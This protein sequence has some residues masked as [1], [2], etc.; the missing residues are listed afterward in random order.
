LRTALVFVGAPKA[1]LRTKTGER[2]NYPIDYR[3]RDFLLKQI[4]NTLAFYDP[5]VVDPAGGFYHCY[6]NNGALFNP[7]LKTLVAS[8]RFVFNYAKAY[9][10]FGKAEYKAHVVHGLRY[11][12]DVHRNLQTGGYAWRIQDG[13]VVD[14]TNHCYGLAFVLLA[15]ACAT[16][17][18]IAEARQWIAETYDLMENRFWLEDYGLY[19]CEADADWTLRAYRGQND[20]MHA[21]EALIAAY[22]STGESRYLERACLLAENI[23]QRQTRETQGH[24]LEHYKADWT[25][26]RDYSRDDKSNAMR[27]WGVQTGH[28]TEWAKLLIILDR[29]QPEEWRLARARELFDR[30]M[31]YGWDKERGGLIHNYDLAGK[32]YDQDKYFWVQAESIAAAALL[33]DRTGLAAYWDWY[34]RI[35][36]YSFHYFVDHVYGAWY[37]ILSPENIRYDDRKSYNNKAD[38]HTM[39]AC[40]EVL[41]V[42]ASV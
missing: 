25:P 41:N 19:A 16:D 18:G 38:Y 10:Q 13:Q 24:L 40:Y 27:P 15:Y 12:R 20:N 2:V 37:R 8:C 5:R 22:Q 34:D 6:M 14:G 32:P 35:W 30:A 29:H 28:Q 31:I 1:W 23:T 7:G 4:S 39:G 26:D 36:D 33:A 3:S 9:L 42:A 21:C 11:L 17:V